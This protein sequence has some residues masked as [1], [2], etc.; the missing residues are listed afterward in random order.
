MK[1]SYKILAAAGMI[2]LS[3][4]SLFAQ[5]TAT[6]TGVVNSC[7][8]KPIQL[9]WD[10]PLN[11]GTFTT[12]TVASALEMDIS[13]I[14]TVTSSNATTMTQLPTILTGNPA[15]L[16]TAQT[17]A[18]SGNPGP[19]TFNVIGQPTFSYTITLP[20]GNIEVTPTIT[21][22]GG[23]SF[24]MQLTN[25]VA[26]VNGAVANGGTLDVHGVSYFGVGAT[27]NIGANQPTGPYTGQFNVSVNYN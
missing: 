9:I 24:P 18:G 22:F 11:F 4:T 26:S 12:P 25:F 15:L 27:L 19:A 2:A 3:A 7:V 21:Q 5:N 16:N 13:G 20:P 14:G 1:T 17:G 23:G 10:H 8:I 6:A